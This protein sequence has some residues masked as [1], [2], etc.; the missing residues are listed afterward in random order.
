LCEAEPG[1]KPEP[2]L[3]LTCPANTSRILVWVQPHSWRGSRTTQSSF[4][5]RKT[6]RPSLLDPNHAPDGR[7]RCAQTTT[8][9]DHKMHLAGMVA[10]AQGGTKTKARAIDESRVQNQIKS[11]DSSRKCTHSWLESRCVPFSGCTPFGF[12]LPKFRLL[13]VL[14]AT[15]KERQG[16]FPLGTLSRTPKNACQIRS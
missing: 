14:W 13:V 8:L 16:R 9:L 5:S 6:P 12:V 2:H 4:T 1:V 11:V 15:L 7:D 10:T 3:H